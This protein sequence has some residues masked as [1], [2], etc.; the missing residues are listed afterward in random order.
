MRRRLI[1]ALTYPRLL[2][3]EGIGLQDCPHDE[4]FDSSSDRCHNCDLIQECHWLSCL[5]SFAVLASKPTHTF[6]A[7]LL[8]S[9]KVINARIEQVGHDSKTCTC[10]SCT[11]TRDAQKLN[12]EY[13]TNCQGDR[14]RWSAGMLSQAGTG[15][16]VAKHTR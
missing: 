11:W 6:H 16:N 8:Y 5:D 4:L 15:K 9:I 10:E 1:E 3:L 7:S 14:H 13:Q 2:I 12:R